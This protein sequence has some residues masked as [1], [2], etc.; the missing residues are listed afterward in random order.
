MKKVIICTTFRDFI[1]GPNDDIQREFL[2]YINNQEYK[3]WLLVVTIYKEKNVEKE[4]LNRIDK[5]KVIFIY[6]K[7]TDCRFSLTEVFLNG[8]NVSKYRNNVVI[9]VNS[10]ILVEP[11]FL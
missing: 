9:W 10:D 4:V 5:S 11:D 6:S 8:I 7:L 2:R 3:N 1:G